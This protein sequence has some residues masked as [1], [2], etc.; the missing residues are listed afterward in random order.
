MT[1]I[2]QFEQVYYRY[3][4]QE[5]FALKGLDLA[6]PIGQKIAVIGRNGA[7]K[8]TLFLLCNGLYRPAAGTVRFAG[9]PLSYDARA[10]RAV[11]QRVGIVF[12]NP[13][14]QLFSA[15]V[16]EDIS[17][18]PLNLG[19]PV[20]EVRHR[21]EMAARMCEVDSFLDRPTHALSSGEKARVALAGVLAME[22]EVVAVDELVANLDPWVSQRILAIFDQ[23]HAQGTTILLSTH[24]LNVVRDWATWVVVMEQGRAAFAGTPQALL[25]DRAVLEQTGLAQVWSQGWNCPRW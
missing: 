13:D 7:G 1:A 22:P 3:E 6:L 2:F 4:G 14:D 15:N 11:R 24:N 23:L 5:A 17:F 8:S 10:L 20:L 21:V 25:A 18:G 12:Q 9:R 19:L 16:E